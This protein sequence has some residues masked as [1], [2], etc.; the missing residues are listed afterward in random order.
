MSQDI[1][2]TAS[3]P[4]R[5]FEDLRGEVSL[6]RLAV[7][8]LSAERRNAPDYLPTLQDIA[9]RLQSVG[10]SLKRIEQA[11]TMVLTPDSFASK[12]KEAAAAARVEDRRLVADAKESLRDSLDR[13]DALV[14]RGWTAERQWRQL[15]WT[16]AIAFALGILICAAVP[17]ILDRRPAHPHL[18]ATFS[19]Q[20]AE[21][22][23][24]DKR[25][26]RPAS[27]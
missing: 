8:G 6:L 20:P 25:R 26:P 18:T 15:L 2:P 17:R 3:D 12:I 9:G 16:G 5:A 7:Q 19:G 14:E 22:T 27:S 23:R 10:Q 24:E 1:V 13:I 4:A 11:P 21:K